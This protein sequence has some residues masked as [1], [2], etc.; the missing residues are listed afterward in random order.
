MGW[1]WVEVDED[2]WSGGGDLVG[3][4]WKEMDLL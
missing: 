1:S 3:M 4:V 2:D